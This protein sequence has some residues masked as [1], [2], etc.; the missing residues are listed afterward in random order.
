MKQQKI[1]ASFDGSQ[2]REN[3]SELCLE[4]LAEQKKTW[5]E[6]QK[7]YEYLKNIKVRDLHCTG[8]SVKIQHNPGRVRS[9]TANIDNAH[10]N[11][12]PCFLCIN[13]LPEPQ[14]G[15]LYRDAYL[16]L[17]NPAPVFPSHLTISCLYHRPQAIAEHVDTLIQLAVDLGKQWAVL[18]NGP[19]CG[20][21]APDHLHFQAVPSGLMP[22]E[23]EKSDEKR[24]FIIREIDGV[25]ISRIHDFGR[26]VI[27]L[28][29]ENK[30]NIVSVFKCILTALTKML[31]TDDEPMINAIVQNNEKSLRFFIFPRAKHRPEAFFG[32]GADRILVS[33][34]V[35][36]M[37]GVIITPIEKDFERLGASDVE[38][39]YKEV[40]LGKDVIYE[41]LSMYA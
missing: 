4:L 30:P 13:N 24:F 26:E 25:T 41:I 34:A 14:K 9:S 37:G 23:K 17:C 6:L 27:T 39:I 33:P 29:G 36:E 20:A 8:F 22:I 15:I 7:A 10:I 12:R 35:I 19:R 40:S 18:Y 28:V 16:I 1:Y 3:L 38:D 31:L 21:S 2:N 11:S 32:T 5:P